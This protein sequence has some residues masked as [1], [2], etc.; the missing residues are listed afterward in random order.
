M[1]KIMLL[2]LSL[3]LLLLPAALAQTPAEME[4]VNCEEWVSLRLQAD[5]ASDRIAQVNLGE[6]V[7]GFFGSHGD[8]SICEYQGRTGYIL[9]QYLQEKEVAIGAQ[10]PEGEPS[11]ELPLADGCIRVWYG[12]GSGEILRLGCYDAQD[13]LMWSYQSETLMSTELTGVELFLNL[14]AEEPMVMVHNADFGLIAL[15]AATGEEKWILSRGEISLGASITHAIAEDGTMYIG[16]YYGPD[17]VCI[18][19][20]GKVKWES[21]SLHDENGSKREFT[22]LDSIVILS[23]GVAAHY[24][25]CG[26]GAWVGYDHSGKMIS[27]EKDA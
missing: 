12:F 3:V 13:A 17:P 19:P 11:Y 27:W 26:E 5:S 18:S 9:N 25:N 7:R 20:E 22:W 16:G 10:L 2:A 14:Q 4:I 1:K 24:D 15:D 21:S 6:T 23:D 8:F